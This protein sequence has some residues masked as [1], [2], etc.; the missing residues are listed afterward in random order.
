MK[1]RYFA[2]KITPNVDDIK[3]MCLVFSSGEN[4]WLTH[5]E[6]KSFRVGLCDKLEHIDR[7]YCYVANEGMVVLNVEKKVDDISQHSHYFDVQ[8]A[9]N[10]LQKIAEKSSNNNP[11]FNEINTKN[12]YDRHDFIN[13]LV[14]VDDCIEKIFVTMGVY[15]YALY[16][17]WKASIEGD[18]IVVTASQGE[19]K[20][21]GTI[22]FVDLDDIDKSKV[23]LVKISTD[24]LGNF[25]V[26]GEEI[27]DLQVEWKDDLR[28]YCE[29]Y[30]RDAKRVV[31]RIKLLSK[32]DE[33]RK[34]RLA[35]FT[36]K[37]VNVFGETERFECT[38]STANDIEFYLLQGESK[39]ATDICLIHLDGE[40]MCQGIYID[41]IRP[42]Q[43]N[44]YE[45][46]DYMS[47]Y[48]IK[49]SDQCILVVLGK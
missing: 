12:I 45:Y 4:F 47:G 30:Y 15:G 39:L 18:N 14:Q 16:G 34:N 22:S 43:S 2:N 21:Q 38:H 5:S 35:K 27:V 10:N 13:H 6:I 11:N 36:S 23:E 19:G 48:A 1:R 42:A 20:C 40:D 46:M 44:Q 8:K 31:M 28:P 9:V 37:K 33:L 29:G 7:T 25:V 32:Y 49:D 17:K 41:D 24:C 26:M 3:E